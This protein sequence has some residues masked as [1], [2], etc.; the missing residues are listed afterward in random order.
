VDEDTQVEFESVNLRLRVGEDRMNNM[1]S[2]IKQNT[3]LT[4]EVRDI[5]EL[6]K[7]FFKILNLL[8]KLIKWV[9]GIAAAVGAVYAAWNN[10]PPPGGH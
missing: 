5:L 6:G 3:I 7:S 8:G 4:Q 1:E 2:L 10:L 9:G